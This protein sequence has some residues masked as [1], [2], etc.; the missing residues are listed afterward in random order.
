MIERSFYHSGLFPPALVYGAGAL[1]ALLLAWLLHAELRRRGQSWRWLLYVTRLGMLAVLLLLLA[2]PNLVQTRY[3]DERGH[4]LLLVDDSASMFVSDAS[5]APGRLLHLATLVDLPSI[6][7]HDRDAQ[8]RA[9]RLAALRQDLAPVSAASEAATAAIRMALPWSDRD[10]AR[11]RDGRDAAAALRRFL[12]D[13]AEAE[14]LPEAIRADAR[15]LAARI[16]EAGNPET[17]TAVMAADLQQAQWL[18]LEQRYAAVAARLE[19]LQGA[20]LAL[21]A[22]RDQ[23]Y[24]ADPATRDALASELGKLTRY[25]LARRILEGLPDPEAR[26]VLALVQ[27]D[28]PVTAAQ[29]VGRTDLVAPLVQALSE[30]PLELLDAVVLVSDGGQNLDADFARLRAY[31]R[32]RI[33]VIVSG[34]GAAPAAQ[35]LRVLRQET[36]AVATK[37]RPTAVRVA[38]QSD[39]P[40]GTEVTVTVDLAHKLSAAEK[41]AAAAT[42]ESSA[43]ASARSRLDR[44]R[45]SST[46]SSAAPAAE[47][48][49]AS[50]A[51]STFPHEQKARVDARGRLRLDLELTI[52]AAGFNAVL[53]T[54]KAA[55]AT[56]DLSLPVYVTAERPRILVVAARPDRFVTAI[57]A[58]RRAGA[59][60]YPVFTYDR[61]GRATR[62]SRRGELP[63]EMA[64]WSQYD[65]V[66][67]HGRPFPGWTAADG[68]ALRAALETGELA[69]FVNGA[70]SEGYLRDIAPALA[71][72]TAGPALPHPTHLDLSPRTDHL[73]PL[74]LRDEV[75]AN[76]NAWQALGAP[77]APRAVPPQDAP[78]LLHPGTGQ[79]VLS[80][81]LIGRGKLVLGGLDGMEAMLAWQ[82]PEYDRFMDGLLG[83]LLTP[84]RRTQAPEG[85]AELALYPAQATVGRPVWVRLAAP[86]GAAAPGS[87]SL[88]GPDGEASVALQPAG[89]PDAA[90]RQW[91]TGEFLP[92]D[93]GDY[94]LAADTL[95]L[96]LAATRLP[97]AETY[98][99]Q[100]DEALL[101]ALAAAA[102]GQYV[103]LGDLP[104]AVAAVTPRTRTHVDSRTWRLLDFRVALLLLFGLLA[105]ADFSLRKLLGL[106]L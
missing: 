9:D 87:L 46:P 73:P 24:L 51:I 82:A 100:L 79:P 94:R 53:L 11:V 37:D 96:T 84:L 83:D 49:P 39:L 74:R 67:L 36:P 43:E 50:S 60:V 72:D 90:G 5:A 16:G 12:L 13:C 70:G 7:A 17:L 15:D 45:R 101:Q 86:P 26:Q 69:L 71:P 85:A 48:S 34:I 75:I 103:A 106:V 55:P 23:D 38:L 58:Q 93:P 14:T 97:S 20:L 65:L 98:D 77:A 18:E 76:F 21:Q 44:Y 54:V 8:G 52:E 22:Q 61:E 57:L 99:T 4:D 10:E 80:L 92:V 19:A 88:Q 95:E 25:D 40:A 104:Q 89:P 31:S 27:G 91:L 42:S 29:A 2:Q 81:G 56:L 66:V 28:T 64:D 30:R 105:I 63:L 3:R 78:L 68:Q 33:P 102:G 47:S 6:Q 59:Q 41:A 32:R 35:G 62:G 1:L